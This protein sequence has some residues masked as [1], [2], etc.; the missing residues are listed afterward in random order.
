MSGAAQERIYDV[1][2]SDGRTIDPD[3]RCRTPVGSTV[4]VS[5][6]SYTNSIGDAVLATYWED[7]DFD[8]SPSAFYYVRVI[9][10]PASALRAKY[11][12]MH[13]I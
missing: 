10:I 5:D 7:T 3:G 9:E 6:A 11:R 13:G 4:G 8:P 12:A 1:A 2:V